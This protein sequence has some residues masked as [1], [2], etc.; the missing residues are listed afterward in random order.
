MSGPPRSV[1][2]S[3]DRLSDVR[4]DRLREALDASGHQLHDIDW[5][6]PHQ[7]SARAIRKGMEELTEAL[8]DAPRNPA[9]VTVDHY[10]NTASTS[11][12]VALVD[13]IEDGRLQAGDRVALVAL[14]SG[15]VV[16]V[17]ITTIDEHLAGSRA[18]VA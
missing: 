11:H 13:M 17:V 18:H 10:G 2:G 6:I 4:D 12:F 1:G 3:D 16:G 5:V 7:T 14:A 8:G 9:V 15:L